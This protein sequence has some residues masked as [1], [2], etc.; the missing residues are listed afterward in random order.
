LIQAVRPDKRKRDIGNL[1][2]AISDILQASNVIV[3][4]CLCE[5]LHMKWVK[6]GPECLV[7]IK[8]HDGE[9]I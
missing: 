9:A 4:D 1:E 3:D 7:M 6:E 5:D 8:A 2:K